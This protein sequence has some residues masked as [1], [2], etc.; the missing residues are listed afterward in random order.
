MHC[1]FPSYLRCV[2]VNTMSGF[3]KSKSKIQG[4]ID[5][6]NLGSWWTNEFTDQERTRIHTLFQPLGFSVDSLTEGNITHTS[7]SVVEFLSTLAGWFYKPEDRPIAHKILTKAQQL[8]SENTSVPDLYF[9]YQNMI[10]IYYKDRDFDDYLGKT[11]EACRKMIALAPQ[12]AQAYQNKFQGG[13][14]G[15]KGYEQLAIILEKQNKYE[16][17]IRLCKQ[18]IQEGWSGDWENRISRCKKK[19]CVHGIALKHD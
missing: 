19:I 4:K 5:Y 18:A 17:V 6:F 11:V 14:L 12:A 7:E 9:L 2:V 1:A 3:Q 10:E 15:H 16:E 8:T 13:L